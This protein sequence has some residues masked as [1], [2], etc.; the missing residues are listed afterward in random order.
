MSFMSLAQ[1]KI[2]YSLL[3][4][5][6]APLTYST[7]TLLNPLLEVEGFFDKTELETWA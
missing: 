1:Q 2:H 6:L 3:I 4:V 5:V 7:T